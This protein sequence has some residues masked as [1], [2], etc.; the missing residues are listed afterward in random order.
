M[1]HAHTFCPA[2][3]FQ[4]LNEAL[5]H[6]WAIPI[7]LRAA[8]MASHLHCG[9]PEAV[10]LPLLLGMGFR[11]EMRFSR[12]CPTHPWLRPLLR[13]QPP[14]FK[15]G[16]RRQRS[17]VPS[18]CMGLGDENQPGL[19]LSAQVLG[20]VFLHPWN[21]RSYPATTLTPGPVTAFR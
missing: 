1:G 9:Q 7:L 13:S 18:G 20:E 12:E 14:V 2:E 8:S 19:K 16:E 15:A 3:L 4:I 5:L 11:L 6:P 21:E 10:K 17:Y